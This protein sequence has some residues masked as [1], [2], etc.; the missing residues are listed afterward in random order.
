MSNLIIE[1]TNVLGGLVSDASRDTH[2]TYNIN[3][4]IEVK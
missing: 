1:N 2:P 4:I 3:N